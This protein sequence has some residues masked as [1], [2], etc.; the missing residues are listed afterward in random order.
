M[1]AIYATTS[2]PDA[3]VP[4]ARDLIARAMLTA[5]TIATLG[6][7][8]LTSGMEGERLVQ[9]C[10]LAKRLK[11][12]GLLNP[13]WITLD[14]DYAQFPELARQVY[15]ATGRRAVVRKMPNG[16]GNQERQRLKMAR[17]HGA[18]GIFV[19]RG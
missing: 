15:G 1:I 14:L 7:R 4:R 3:R 9:T 16:H 10:G 11:T 6:L 13:H 19:D 2:V 18:D 12:T 5:W 8:E 17:G